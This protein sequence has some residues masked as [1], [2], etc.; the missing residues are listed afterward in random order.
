M[1]KWLQLWAVAAVFFF[2]PPLHYQ[3][4]SVNETHYLVKARPRINRLA[5][6]DE[7]KY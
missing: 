7:M 4:V 2:F 1:F 6:V 3:H 5:S